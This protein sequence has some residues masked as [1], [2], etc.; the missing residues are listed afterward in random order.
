[1]RALPPSLKLRRTSLAP[2][3]QLRH[4]SQALQPRALSTS[5][6]ARIVLGRAW[7]WFRS[8]DDPAA[9]SAAV[10]EGLSSVAV[11]GAGAFPKGAAAKEDLSSVATD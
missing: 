10:K 7:A 11:D 8:V 3:K 4:N 1:V 5:K 9:F 6:I 2:L